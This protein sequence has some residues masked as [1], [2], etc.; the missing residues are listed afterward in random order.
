MVND[1]Q[2]PRKKLSGKASENGISNEQKR[3]NVI[4]EEMKFVIPLSIKI[5]LHMQIIF[6]N[7]KCSKSKYYGSN[8]YQF[9]HN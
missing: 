9:C 6:T 5:G 4:S 1:S 7:G 8:S 2:W 3:A